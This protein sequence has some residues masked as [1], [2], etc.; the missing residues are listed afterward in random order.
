MLA[1][2]RPSRGNQFIARFERIMFATVAASHFPPRAIATPGSFR[3][4]AICL[5]DFAP[6]SPTY[7]T[8]R[9]RTRDDG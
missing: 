7:A 3:A 1:A 4:A 6:V 9:R 5:K 2:P 8:S